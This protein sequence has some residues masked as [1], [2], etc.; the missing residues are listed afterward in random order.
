MEEPQLGMD[1]T[2]VLPYDPQ[3]QGKI[4][5]W[6][7]SLKNKVLLEKR[8]SEFVEY[9]NHERYQE[10]LANLTPAAVYYWRGQQVR[11]SEERRLKR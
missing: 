9:C 3:T 6:H 4:E 11:P 2:R 8:I 5:R 7:C 10:S 1:H